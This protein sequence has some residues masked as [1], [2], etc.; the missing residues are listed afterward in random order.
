MKTYI[1]ISLPLPSRE[2]LELLVQALSE[3]GF[4]G[5]Q[6]TESEL[7]SYVNKAAW[8]EKLD[9]RIKE[10]LNNIAGGDTAPKLREIREQNWNQE[11]EKTIRPIEIGKSILIKPTWCT[12]QNTGNRIVIQ[13]DPKM[14]FGTGYHETTRLML[15][16]LEKYAHSSQSVLDVGTG[17]GVLAIA[18]VKLGASRS[19]A[20]DT[21]PWSLENARENIELNGVAGQVSLSGDPLS[22]FKSAG[23]DLVAA[24]LTLNTNI[25]LLPEFLRIL[26]KGGIL[27]LSGML[28]TDRESILKSFKGTGLEFLEELTENEWIAIAAGKNA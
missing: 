9:L 20:V 1:E 10:I 19:A 11:W 16:M 28:A 8:N 26:K 14:S 24:N 12:E 23:W 4:E 15:R 22:H 2:E 25:L 18:A 27:L 13:I 6:E 21:D 7:L 3:L 5:F 17:T